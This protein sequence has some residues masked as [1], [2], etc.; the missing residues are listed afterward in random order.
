M[1]SARTQLAARAAEMIRWLRDKC[2]DHDRIGGRAVVV[3]TVLQ[4]EDLLEVL[5][6]LT[7]GANDAAG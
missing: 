5:T 7:K 2:V 4:T 6:E 3:M 1:I